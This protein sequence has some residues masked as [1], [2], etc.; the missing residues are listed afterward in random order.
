MG[1]PIT[2]TRKPTTRKGTIRFEAN[3][4]LTGMGHERYSSLDEAAA[5]MAEHSVD[6]GVQ[7][8]ELSG[9]IEPVENRIPRVRHRG[10][11]KRAAPLRPHWGAET[12]AS[13]PRGSR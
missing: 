12:T 3:R 1:Q 10:E 5:R 6:V 13:R 11:P 2:V 8:S 4:S 9:C 7:T